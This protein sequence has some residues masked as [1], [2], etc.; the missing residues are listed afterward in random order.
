[1][2]FPGVVVIVLRPNA[3][4]TTVTAPSLSGYAD[5]DG[6]AVAFRIR[7]GKV[8][9]AGRANNEVAGVVATAGVV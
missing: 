9:G 1:M 8:L 3:R 4:G 6:R 7:A 5:V 2:L